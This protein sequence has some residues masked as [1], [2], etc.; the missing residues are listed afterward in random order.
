M[1]KQR[2]RINGSASPQTEPLPAGI[3][4]RG[5]APRSALSQ[6]ELR[7]PRPYI[8]PRHP[9]GKSWEFVNKDKLCGLGGSPAVAREDGYYVL[10]PSRPLAKNR[11]KLHQIFANHRG[12][13]SPPPIDMSEARFGLVTGET[14]ESLQIVSRSRSPMRRRASRIAYVEASS[15]S[16]PTL[17]SSSFSSSYSRGPCYS[18]PA[19]SSSSFAS[20]DAAGPIVRQ[21]LECFPLGFP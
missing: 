20:A 7:I 10:P 3:I 11:S 13:A 16:P 4:S 8:G 9:R 5:P 6:T 15:T 18:S 21:S 2:K 19:S 14:I 12:T 1:K 17:F